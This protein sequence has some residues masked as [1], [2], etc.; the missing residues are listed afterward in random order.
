MNLKDKIINKLFGNQLISLSFSEK[1][2][3]QWSMRAMIL[4]ADEEGE[5]TIEERSEFQSQGQ[6][7]PWLSERKALPVV[8]TIETGEILCRITESEKFEKEELL[9]TIIPQ[10]NVEDFFL[11]SL[12]EEDAAFT[13]IARKHVV[14]DVL[15]MLPESTLVVDVLLGPIA[16]AFLAK[17]LSQ[18][19]ISLG[20]HQFILEEHTVKEYKAAVSPSLPEPLSKEG[21]ELPDLESYAAGLTFFSNPTFLSDYDR[22]YWEDQQLHRTFFNRYA[23]FILGGVLLIFLINAFLFMEFSSRNNQLVQEN[24]GYLSVKE[25]LT[26]YN[27]FIQENRALLEAEDARFTKLVDQLAS[28]IPQ[29]IR[30]DYMEISPLYLNDKIPGKPN[31]LFLKGRAE[32][33]RDFTLWLESINQLEWIEDILKNEYKADVFGKGVG[34]FQLE[35]AIEG[36]V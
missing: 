22:K 5:I 30:L 28:T 36:D 34:E 13:A 19:S 32:Q 10:S 1:E 15:A 16:F 35:I 24:S 7:S 21:L 6:L 2:F 25:K 9:R 26:S 29:G 14:Q 17:A 23:K 4:S 31:M 18:P 3:G 12:D 11:Q 20:N 27:D 8:L 33:S